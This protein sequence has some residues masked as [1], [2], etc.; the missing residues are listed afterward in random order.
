MPR[1]E[2]IDSVLIIGSGGIRIAQAAEFDYSGS[3]AL[4]ALREEGIRSILVNPNVATIQTSLK[5]ADKV[6]LEP[7]TPETVAEVIRREKPDGILLGFGGQTALNVGV[8]LAKMG[9]LEE[10]GVRVLGSSIKTI[11]MGENRGLF[12]EALRR[13]GVPT[14]VSDTAYSVEEA[15]GIAKDLGYPVVIR[16]AYTLGGGGSGIA[17]NPDELKEIVSRALPLSLEHQVLI[18]QYLEH[19]KEIEF[20]VMRDRADNTKITCAM[21]NFDP[22]GIHTG[23]SIVVTPTQTLT[24][25]EYQMLRSASI[26]I[27]RTLKI[28][29]ECNIQFG[30]NPETSEYVAIELNPRMSRSSAL[31]SKATG[32]PLA[33]IATKLCIG[34]LLPELLNKV[35]GS[36]TACFEPALDYIVV[37]IPRWDFDKFPGPVDRRIGTQMKSVGEVMAIARSFEEALQ[38]AIRGLRIGKIGL[39]GNE[40]DDDFEPLD[41]LRKE[42]RYP[43]DKRIFKIAK[44]IK[45]GLSIEEIA[46]LTGIDPWFLYKIKRITDMEET[47]RN[48]SL[49]ESEEIL[50][51]HIQKAKRLG[52]SD[53]QIAKYLNT[54]EDAIRSFR[55]KRGIVPAFKKIDTTA[56]EW[57][58]VTNYCYATYGDSEDDVDSRAEK[59]KV[60]ILGAGCFQIGSSVEFDYSTMNTAWS[61]KEEGIDEVIVLNNNPET[62]STDFD[63]SDKLYFEEITLERVLDIVDKERPMG[64]IVSVGGQT[65]NSLA[66]P[67]A[68]RGVKL[69]GT[70]AESIDIAEDRSKFSSLLDKLGIPQ[71]PWSSVTSLRG[72]REFARKIGYPVMVRPSYVLSGA[73]MRVAQ[74]EEELVDYIVRATR[75]SPEHPVVVSKFIEGAREVEV[76]AVC[77]GRDVLIGAIIEHVELAGTHSGDATMVIPPQTLSQSVIATIE[78]YTR[79]L[80]RELR[81]QGPFN[82]QYLVKGGTV[83]VIE[84]NLRAS[85]SLPFTSKAAGVPL[86]KIAAK[87]ILGKTLRELDSL[88]RTEVLHTSVKAPMFSFMRVKGADPILGVEMVSTGEVACMDYDFAGALAKALIASELA[89][90]DPSKPV[91]ITVKKEDRGRAVDLSKRLHK[92]GYK[93]LA[94]KGTADAMREAGIPVEEVG[95]VSEAEDIVERLKRREIGLVINTPKPTRWE[96]IDDSYV[97]RRTAVEFMIPVIT[98]IEAAE[99]LVRVLEE[100]ALE[101]LQVRSLNELIGHAPLGREV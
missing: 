7:T 100:G 74:S 37:K 76:D 53:K 43:T 60:L 22:L 88:K 41:Q 29:G 9:V 70:A 98:R 86:A 34:Y 67:L 93:I 77:D 36:T 56:A 66:L 46:K 94:T 49:N 62:V 84:L 81:I 97:I 12:K 47:L 38:K 8:Q 64:V 85:R 10:E 59:K 48:L 82:I 63:M 80:A 1:L 33:Y 13:A 89:M 19:W 68:R 2:G 75:V 45:Q 99:A 11:E 21:E 27:V 96:T 4:K 57:A 6:Y 79:K 55:K 90:P 18:E 16:V 101:R 92:L 20:E 23:E 58:S 44:A 5:L 50:A 32:Y 39:V 54:N 78:D 52:F 73:A 15:L 35:T 51:K 72:A 3:Q 69:L 28:I 17:Y 87:A 24:N 40:D 30:L 71:P 26:R 25:S 91:L 14:P 42:L 61:L 65:P 31:A 83:Y 95:K